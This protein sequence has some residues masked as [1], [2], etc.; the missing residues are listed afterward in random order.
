MND[1]G[2]RTYWRVGYREDPVGF[3]PLELCTWSFRFDDV[4][5]RFRSVYAAE[6]PETAIREVLADL[7]PNAA[8]I[9]RYVERFGPQAAH[10]VPSRP[11]T[12]SW[13]RQH[14]LVEVAV[15]AHGPIVDLCD[16]DARYEIG[17]HH[18]ELLTAH[19]MDHLDLSEIT[20][21]RRPVTQTIAADLHDRLGAAGVRFPSRLGG[22]PCLAVFEGTGELIVAGEPIA[23]TD[24][25]PAALRYVCAGWRMELTPA[26][27][28]IDTE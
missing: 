11:V 1:A 27:P 21:R 12:E 16:P 23:L 18:A 8:A 5:R 3:V 22:Q 20:A 14:V 2:A 26:D 19:G 4:K 28:D 15:D 25:A 7:R 9:G 10:D 24:P 13:R 17:L 6:R